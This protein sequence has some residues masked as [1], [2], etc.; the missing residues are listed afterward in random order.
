M[1]RR[2]LRPLLAALGL[3]LCRPAAAAEI[4]FEPPISAEQEARWQAAVE[5]AWNDWQSRFGVTV[6]MPPTA[7]GVSDVTAMPRALGRT[8]AGR[9]ELN[10]MLPAEAA[11]TVLRHEFAHSFLRARCPALEVAAPLP[12]EAFALWASGDAARRA[13]DDTRF[14]YA[15]S[16]RDWLVAHRASRADDPSAEQALSRVL[17]QPDRHDAWEGY[18]GRLLRSCPDVSFSPGRA[19]DELLEIAGAGSEPTAGGID[20]LLVD[21]LSQEILASD[22]RPRDRFPTGSILK[23]TL[24]ATVPALMEPHPARDAAVWHCP[25]AP[26]P[27]VVW[28]WQR[29]LVRSCNGF[30]LDA[31]PPS[32]GAFRPWE[33][34][35][36]RLGLT[37]LPDTMEGRIGVRTEFT[38]SPLEAVRLYAWLCRRAPFVVD[39]L[40]RTASEGTLAGAPG[41]AWF[42]E[43]GVALKSGTVRDVR[44]TP[45]H[46][47]I[48]AVGPREADGSPRWLAALH[49]GG[50][51][52]SALLPELQRRLARSLTGLERVAR[53]QVLGLVHRAG[54]GVACEDGTPMLLRDEAGEWRVER[55]GS[56]VP[57]GGLSPAFTYLCPAGPLVLSFPDARGADQRRRYWGSLRIDPLPRG[58]PES[59]VPLRGKSARAR[60]GSELVLATSEASYALSSVL[61]ELPNAR[62]ETLKALSLV[63]RNNLRA[64][65]HGERPVCDTTHCELYGHDESASAG[66][67]IRA[68]SAIADVASTEIAP[69]PEG[70][71]WLPFFLGGQA[72]WRETRS[73][74]AVEE[75]LG[76]DAAPARIVKVD[77]ATVAVTAGV[78]RTFPCELFRNQLR[79]LSCPDTVTSIA[80]GF[81]FRGRGEGHGEGLD[82]VVAETAAAQGSDYHAVLQRF[83]PALTL[84]PTQQSEPAPRQ[85]P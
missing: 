9:I 85:A 12:S 75:A 24:V 13:F 16:A 81:E 58:E 11:L 42:V 66:Q 18:F 73:A 38:I 5:A 69:G 34:E 72:P 47:W 48:V 80:S 77:A 25:D 46:A 78:E 1:R 28:T 84:R 71:A 15:S 33:E 32:P 36:G 49:A 3:T 63:L 17:A 64:G 8:R 29:A 53:V 23:P 54:V 60:I 65:R 74:A 57:P 82:L 51:A 31:A 61:S 44:G 52:T 35:L 67:R 21:G 20:F 41:A 56:A 79:L 7:V 45:L 2:S 6:P 55:P 19:V 62:A 30:F 26:Q 76:L 70:R 37:G 4:R 40:T 10:R 68:R 50:R 59:S 14:V 22:G 43:R 83:Y 27:G 39:A